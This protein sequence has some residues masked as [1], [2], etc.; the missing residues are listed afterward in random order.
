MKTYIVYANDRTITYEAEFA[1]ATDIDEVAWSAALDFLSS[2][3]FGGSPPTAA[4]PL[5]LIITVCDDEY[6]YEYEYEFDSLPSPQKNGL[7]RVKDWR[8]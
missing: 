5:R 8:G 6:E 7:V 3:D 4:N 2:Y 1:V